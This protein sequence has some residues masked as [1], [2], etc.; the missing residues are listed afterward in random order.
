MKRTA[1]VVA[2]L[3]AVFLLTSSMTQTPARTTYRDTL[4]GLIGKKCSLYT[5]DGPARLIFGNKDSDYEIVRVGDDYVEISNKSDTRYL[6]LSRVETV[7]F[8]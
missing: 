6:P 1:V 2:L 4:A 5:S 8:K 7:I 3:A